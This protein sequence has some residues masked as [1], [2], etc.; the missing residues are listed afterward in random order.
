MVVEAATVVL[1]D[2]SVMVNHRDVTVGPYRRVTIYADGG[3][4]LLRTYVDRGL[5]EPF[6]H[7]SL[8]RYSLASEGGRDRAGRGKGG[9]VEE[10]R[11][12]E[13]RVEEGRDRILFVNPPNRGGGSYNAGKRVNITISVAR[14]NLAWLT[15]GAGAGEKQR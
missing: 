8:A 7:A 11:G 4:R 10:G 2:G 5:P 15:A 1:A 3:T 6:C 13:D 14:L 9:R 12:E